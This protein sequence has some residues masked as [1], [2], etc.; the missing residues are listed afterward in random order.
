MASTALLARTSAGAEGNMK[1]NQD[2]IREM[3]RMNESEGTVGAGA[4]GHDEP[5]VMPMRT[6]EATLKRSLQ[7]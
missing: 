3:L 5:L 7:P 1:V 4:S 6:A 2:Y